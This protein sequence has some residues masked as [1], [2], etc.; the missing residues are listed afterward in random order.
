MSLCARSTSRSREQSTKRGSSNERFVYSIVRITR[1]YDYNTRR[2][3]SFAKFTR[4][5]KACGL[6]FSRLC[7]S[8]ADWLL[9][10]TA[11]TRN[12]GYFTS[13]RIQLPE[14]G[15]HVLASQKILQNRKKKSPQPASLSDVRILNAIA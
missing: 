7:F 6:I 11:I 15:K 9:R 12:A 2:V 13:I 10:Q 3:H 1:F 5:A 4:C 8:G 14:T